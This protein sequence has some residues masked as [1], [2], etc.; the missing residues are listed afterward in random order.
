MPA[1]RR[2]LAVL[3]TSVI[4]LCLV[5][6]GVAAPALGARK[7]A[8]RLA[9]PD[10]IS[11]AESVAAGVWGFAACSGKVEIAWRVRAR[12]V[13]AVSSWANPISAYGYPQRN[14]RCRVEF[15]PSTAWT[16]AKFCT[17]L[18]H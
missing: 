14:F 1:A 10:A 8:P 4:V 5:P 12:S 2:P 6:L 16:W 17:V 7:R 11:T 13:N 3:L 15:N 18:V 9:S